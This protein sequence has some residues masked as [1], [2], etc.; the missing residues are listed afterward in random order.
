MSNRPIE[1]LLVERR[2]FAP[3]EAFRA[4][5]VIADEGVYEAAQRDPEGFWAKAADELH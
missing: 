5:A 1:T 3:P 2:N 4:N